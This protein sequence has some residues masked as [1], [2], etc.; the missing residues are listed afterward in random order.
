MTNTPEFEIN[1][2]LGDVTLLGSYPEYHALWHLEKIGVLDDLH[3]GAS[4]AWDAITRAPV[5]VALIDTAVA[6]QNPNLYDAIDRAR[7]I[8]FAVEDAG[9][10]PVAY[11]DLANTDEKNARRA[12]DT[13]P[14]GKRRSEQRGAS[15]VSAAFAGHGTAMAGLIGARPLESV[16][17]PATTAGE[18]DVHKTPT[19]HV[20]SNMQG[21]AASRR[22]LV[23]PY[24][25]VNPSCRIVPISTS[26]SPNPQMLLNAFAYAQE[27]EADVIVFATALVPE[28]EGTTV[29][30]DCS[31]RVP[32]PA[33]GGALTPPWQALEDKIVEIGQQTYVVCAAGNAGVDQPVYPA[34]LS[35]ADNKIIAVGALASD[36]TLV[37]YATSDADVYVPSGDAERLDTSGFRTDPFAADRIGLPVRPEEVPQSHEAYAQLISTDVPG[38]FGYNPSPYDYT[39]P[40]LGPHLEVASLFCEFSGTSGA[41]AVAGGLIA[42]ALQQKP[43]AQVNVPKKAPGDT[44]TCLK[45]SQL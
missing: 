37:A 8:D 13:T 3:S 14:E 42:L 33:V 27:I 18:A 11:D 7:M 35:T 9:A 10:F 28:F 4:A 31:G 16:L 5:T 29:H 34:S 25:G 38:P 1:T 20:P 6:W 39:P 21:R 17:V 44:P 22:D 23:I 32:T 40:A 12:V 24:A 30:S 19:L 15:A 26:Q 45:I 43:A 41:A 2:D 36:D